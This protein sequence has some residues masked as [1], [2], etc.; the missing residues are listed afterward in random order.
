VSSNLTLTASLFFNHLRGISKIR[1]QWWVTMLRSDRDLWRST[2]IAAT[3]GSKANA[4]RATLPIPALMSRTNSAEAG[5]NVT[6]LS[7][8]AE[9]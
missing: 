9:P 7:I 6:V 4:L 5:E 8:F 2:S 3:T 1:G